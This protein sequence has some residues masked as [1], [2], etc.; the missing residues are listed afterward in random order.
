MHTNINKKLSVYL[1][2]LVG[3]WLLLS[4]QNTYAINW[5]NIDSDC[6][7]KVVQSCCGNWEQKICLNSN[8]KATNPACAM[9]DCAPSKSS[10]DS[11]RKKPQKIIEIMTVAVSSINVKKQKLHKKLI[12]YEY[13]IQS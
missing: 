2:V 7:M 13:D 1:L 12:D 4:T 9:V 3:L 11:L 5:C 8:S 10:E 6:E